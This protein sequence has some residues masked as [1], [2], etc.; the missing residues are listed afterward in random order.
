MNLHDRQP[1]RVEFDGERASWLRVTAPALTSRSAWLNGTP[2]RLIDGSAPLVRWSASDRQ[3]F[4][5]RATPSVTPPGQRVELL[6]PHSY[7]F[8]LLDARA[9]AC[10]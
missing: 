5:R 10:L 3:S 1:A 4:W 9:P 8:V 7:A 2:L 6:P